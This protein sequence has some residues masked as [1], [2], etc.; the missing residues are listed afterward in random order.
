[1]E[2]YTQEQVQQALAQTEGWQLDTNSGEIYRQ[3]QFGNFMEALAF[4]NKIGEVAEEL[5]HHPDI[6]I[7]YNKVSLSV[8]THDAGGLTD[9]DFTLAR[10]ANG[11][12]SDE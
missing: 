12:M 4:V 3:Y 10:R 7:K 2:A 11:V 9:K 5:G 1:M 8:T 6:T